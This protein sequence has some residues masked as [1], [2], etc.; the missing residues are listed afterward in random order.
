[1]IDELL[2]SGAR[3]IEAPTAVPDLPAPRRRYPLAVASG[4]A[5]AAVIGASLAVIS[6]SDSDAGPVIASDPSTTTT[7]VAST[8]TTAWDPQIPT[9]GWTIGEPFASQWQPVAVTAGFGDG[10]RGDYPTATLMRLVRPSTAEPGMLDELQI[11]RDPWLDPFV[12]IPTAAAPWRPQRAGEVGGSDLWWVSAEHAQYPLLI[13]DG[14][15]ERFTID[16]PV[17]L[18]EA[19]LIAERLEAPADGSLVLD[20]PGGWTLVDVLDPLER[21]GDMTL[22]ETDARSVAVTYAPP[23]YVP[24]TND[25]RGFMLEVITDPDDPLSA[26]P[27]RR[28]STSW[29]RSPVVIAGVA[30]VVESGELRWRPA[31]DVELRLRTVEL[32]TGRV[33]PELDQLLAIAASVRPATDDEWA[34]IIATAQANSEPA[35]ASPA[36]QARAL[37]RT[38]VEGPVPTAAGRDLLLLDNGEV[39]WIT[40]DYLTCDDMTGAIDP[41]GVRAFEMLYPEVPG[42]AQVIVGTDVAEVSVV[43]GAAIELTTPFPSHAPDYRIGF[44]PLTGEACFEAVA[45][46]E[47]SLGA[48]VIADE[49]RTAYERLCGPDAIPNDLVVAERNGIELNF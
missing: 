2:R 13:W 9:D 44:V 36:D 32:M 42:V 39:C 31:P 37:G 10:P 38:I 21:V 11:A 40:T 26:S 5:V 46:D 49:Y 28:R 8:P 15:G 14:D 19:M 18:D 34:A 3:T 6:R 33:G 22:F 47:T 35:I 41:A 1:V 43:G 23:D 30:G 25:V 4:V 29:D 20:P 48:V 16:G 17:E 7:T 24:G 27:L 12:D 45:G